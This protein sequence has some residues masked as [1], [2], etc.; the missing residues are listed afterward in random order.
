MRK[1]I[2]VK[3]PALSRSGYG[4]QSRFSLRSMRSREDLFDI[5]LLNIPWGNTGMIAEHSEERQW[6]DSLILKTNQYVQECQ[7]QGTNPQF[8]MSFQVTIPNEFERIA[9]VNIG[10]TAGIETNKIAPQWIEMINNTMDKV[11]T[12]SS[13]S[14]KVIEKTTY[15]V[16][17]PHTGEMIKNWRVTKPVEYI[18][19]PV[20]DIEPDPNGVD[21]PFET[22]KNFLCVKQWGIRKN[23][24][25][26]VRA[27]CSE[28]SDDPDVG[29][30]LKLNSANESIMDRVHTKKRLQALIHDFPDRKCKIYLVHG[31][32]SEEQMTWLYQHPTMQ[33]LISLSHGEGFGLPLFEASY[34]SLPIVTVT[35]GG[36]MDFICRPNKKGKQVPRVARVDYDLAPVQEAARWEG[37]IQADSMWTYAKEASYRRALREVIDK[38]VHFKNQA[39]ALKKYVDT[40][41][42]KEG[43][44]AKF[45][46]LIVD[47]TEVDVNEWLEGFDLEVHD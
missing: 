5:H 47:E 33:A 1:R 36:Q 12:I 20:K 3:A 15:D 28:F 31:Q 11:I 45:V 2:L 23:V 42:S 26:T 38:P 16:P 13:H 25:Q 10:Y 4:E 18:S 9:P 7:A 24:E 32:L 6:L 27:F 35:W 19:Y 30:V 41:F 22:T 39:K 37:V 46:S 14:K 29:L 8:D 44:Y 17:N 21:I 40:N 34:N 43:Q